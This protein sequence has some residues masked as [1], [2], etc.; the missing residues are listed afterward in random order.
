M[1]SDDFFPYTVDWSE[2]DKLHSTM[3]LVAHADRNGSSIC[4]HI[5]SIAQ[6]ILYGKLCTDDFVPNLRVESHRET[7]LVIFIIR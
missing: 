7:L 2:D 3:H 4:I 1:S 5:I 6:I